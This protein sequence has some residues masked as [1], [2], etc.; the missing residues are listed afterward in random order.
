M[1]SSITGSSLPV[2]AIAF[3]LPQFH[4]IAENDRWWGAGFT[5]WTNVTRAQ[6]HLRR[7]LSAAS[8]GAISGFY[9]LRVAEV[10]RRSRSALAR[11]LRHSRVLLLLLLVCRQAPAR[12]RRWTR[13]WRIRRPDFPFCLCWANENWTR[14]WD[15][16]D[17]EILIGQQHSRADDDAPHPRPAAA[18]RAIRA[19]SASNGRPLF[20]VYRVG[21]LP[22]V[23]NSASIWRDVCRREGI[24][25]LYL[26]RSQDLRHG[27]SAHRT[28]STPRSNF[29]PTA[30]ACRRSTIRSTCTT[31][32]SK[33]RSSTT[34]SSSLDAARAA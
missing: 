15:G 23:R 18:L 6:P 20:I 4:P 17:H 27:R 14:R 26:C 29:R 19:T 11:A 2:R 21:V 32:I 22:D 16:A 5:E 31:P 25:E 13:C 28:D 24:G 1:E 8:S 34:G 10:A 12:A 33:D 9:D 3:H 7:P 30:C